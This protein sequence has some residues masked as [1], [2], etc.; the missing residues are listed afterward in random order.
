MRDRHEPRNNRRWCPVHRTR[1]IW[2]RA[3]CAYC[4]NQ[5]HL[6]PGHVMLAKRGI[7]Q[8]II[9]GRCRKNNILQVSLDGKRW[10]LSA[11]EDGIPV[12]QTHLALKF[13]VGGT[14]HV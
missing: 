2:L 13:P 7:A 8:P 9:C 4:H 5:A 10:Y 11:V 3:P 14:R 12:I 1:D 6:H